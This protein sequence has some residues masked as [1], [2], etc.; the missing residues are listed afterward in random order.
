MRR[1]YYNETWE[2]GTRHQ[3]PCQ[4]HGL[5]RIRGCDFDF[6]DDAADTLARPDKRRHGLAAG[7]RANSAGEGDR[8][9]VG[10]D[11]Q[12]GGGPGGAAYEVPYGLGQVVIH[13]GGAD[14]SV[15][16]CLV[17]PAYR[18]GLN[19]AAG[20]VYKGP[21]SAE[22]ACAARSLRPTRSG[23]SHSERSAESTSRGAIHLRRPPSHAH[24]GASCAINEEEA[25]HWAAPPVRVSVSPA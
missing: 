10:L 20:H 2:V 8:A 23:P 17:I 12:G 15:H 22:L 18:L 19:A 6:A 16:C 21:A 14:P 5:D 7:L 4:L 24:G 1:T 11:I 3:I 9:V 25:A 13:D